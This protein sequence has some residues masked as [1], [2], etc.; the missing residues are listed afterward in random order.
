[1]KRKLAVF[2][3]VLMLCLGARSLLAELALVRVQTCQDVANQCTLSYGTAFPVH[4]LPSGQSL[5]LTA[6]HV[7]RG[8]KRVELGVNGRW[9]PATI[10]YRAAN[11]QEPDVAALAATVQPLRNV[12]CLSSKLRKGMRV[13]CN[14]Y[15]GGNLKFHSWTATVIR[16]PEQ[17]NG[18]ARINTAF[19]DGDSGGPVFADGKVVGLIIHNDGQS[20]L[21]EFLPAKTIARV[22]KQHCRV[23]ILCQPAVPVVPVPVPVP[24]PPTA[25]SEHAANAKLDELGRRVDSLAQSVAA[26]AQ[27]A[28]EQQQRL[29]ELANAI[30][31][32]P[33]PPPMDL[34]P[35]EKQIG[36]LKQK[37]ESLPAPKPPDLTP[38]QEDIKATRSTL[39]DR[40]ARV[41]DGVATLSPLVWWALGLGGT[42]ATGGTAALAFAVLR[43]LLRARR[44]RKQR[45]AATELPKSDAPTVV[46]TS[47]EATITPATSVPTEITQPEERKQ[48]TIHV[49]ADCPFL[50]N[51]RQHDTFS[52]KEDPQV[53][54]GTEQPSRQAQKPVVVTTESPPPPQA[55]IPETRYVRVER[56]TFADAYDYAKREFVRNYPGAAATFQAVDNMIEQYMAAQGIKKGTTQ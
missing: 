16:L 37:M 29:D 4:R 41:A 44:K 15:G 54:E 55:I 49:P 42:A 22:I 38:I 3:L 32:T 53:S 25:S 11:T 20:G 45:Q 17:N 28:K 52:R 14:G 10:L 50:K 35:I 39:N 47:F 9:Y 12:Y 46:P 27:N 21:G 56:D 1:M 13:A 51:E 23:V 48:P 34:S 5:W 31:K 7:V 2:W 33:P 6:S 40:I 26:L 43:T 19:S 8:A 36:E 30:S 18:W 24:P